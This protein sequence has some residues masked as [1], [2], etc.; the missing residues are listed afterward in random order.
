MSQYYENGTNTGMLAAQDRSKSEE[1]GSKDEWQSRIGGCLLRED[2]YLARKNVGL[3]KRGD[4]L[5]ED[6]RG[7]TRK[8]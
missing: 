2:R 7:L 3:A 5:T 8:D 6:N 4:G 1:D